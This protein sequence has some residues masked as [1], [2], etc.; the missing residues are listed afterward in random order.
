MSIK[1]KNTDLVSTYKNCFSLRRRSNIFKNQ[2]TGCRLFILKITES[3]RSHLEPGTNCNTALN[4]ETTS[5]C[6]TF[7]TSGSQH[8]AC[9]RIYGRLVKQITGLDYAVSDSVVLE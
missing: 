4:D 1:S 9:I 5:I 3:Q 8:G 7:Q 2:K 6:L